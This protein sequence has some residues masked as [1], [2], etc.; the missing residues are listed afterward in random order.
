M[1]DPNGELYEKNEATK[2]MLLE[3]IKTIEEFETLFSKEINGFSY[4]L[5]FNVEFLIIS[6]SDIK[7]SLDLELNIDNPDNVNIEFSTNIFTIRE[8]QMLY[9]KYVL[10]KHQNSLIRNI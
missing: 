4:E 9:C 7:N 3:K 5:P 2:E 10:R 8:W 1:I 6:P